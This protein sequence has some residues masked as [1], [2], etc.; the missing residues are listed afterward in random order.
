M[1]TVGSELPVS[2]RTRQSIRRLLSKAMICGVTVCTCCCGLTASPSAQAAEKRQGEPGWMPVVVARGELREQI[3]SMPIEA[4]PYRPLHF[5]GNTVRRRYYR[6]TALPTAR[7][8]AA[9][10]ARVL[11]PRSRKTVEEAINNERPGARQ[12][13]E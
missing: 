10:P 8:V 2:L 9:L 5:Y 1:G 13:Q 6:G 12:R 4:R 7:E 3:E 11:M